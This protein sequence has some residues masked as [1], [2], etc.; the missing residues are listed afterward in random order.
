[1][2]EAKTKH[3]DIEKAL[4]GDKAFSEG[5]DTYEKL[6]E[7]AKEVADELTDTVVK[8]ILQSKEEGKVAFNLSSAILAVSKML[9]NLIT[10][11]YDSEDEFYNDRTRARDLVANRIFPVL[12]NGIPCGECE[13]CKNGK[14]EDCIN[15]KLETENTQTRF[16]PILA[17]MIIE[18]DLWTKIMYMY[19]DGKVSLDENFIKEAEEKKDGN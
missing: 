12:L 8:I 14:P 7:Q 6:S 16:L 11:A 5:V 3:V 19:T 2:E 15:P 4:A 9:T 17:N 10:Y 1:M 13:S 18:Y